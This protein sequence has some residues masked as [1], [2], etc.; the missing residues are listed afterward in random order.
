ML[1]KLNSINVLIF[2]FIDEMNYTLEVLNVIICIMKFKINVIFQ[3]TLNVCIYRF[4]YT[5]LSV[6]FCGFLYVYPP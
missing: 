2:I 1:D 6:V 3:L 4:W 5:E